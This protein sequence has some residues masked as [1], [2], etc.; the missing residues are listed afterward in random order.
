M[1][2]GCSCHSNIKKYFC[3]S[4]EFVIF[5]QN[6]KNNISK[7]KI[8]EKNITLIKKD[9]ENIDNTNSNRARNSDKTKNESNKNNTFNLSNKNEYNTSNNNENK[10]KKSSFIN[11]EN[12]SFCTFSENFKKNDLK[13]CNAQNNYDL[14][15]HNNKKDSNKSKNDIIVEE[16]SELKKSGTNF[17]CNL[18][19]HNFIFINVSGGQSFIQNECQEFESITPKMCIENDNIEEIVKGNKRIFSHFCNNKPNE[20]QSKSKIKTNDIISKEEKGLIDINLYMSNYS[21]E[22]LNV[23]NS[24]RKD[25]QSFI[26][27]ID[28]VINNNIQRDNDDIYIV[29]KIFEEKIKITEDFLDV[30]EELKTYLNEIINNSDL[31]SLEE[32]KYNKELEITFDGLIES[33]KRESNIES[34]IINDKYRSQ[35]NNNE[36]VKNKMSNN[37]SNFNLNDDI[38][39]YLILEKRK[40]IKD[41]YPESVFKMSIIRDIKINM[42]AQILMELFYLKNDN[43]NK[44]I[45]KEIIFNPKYKTFANSL[46]Y[47]TNRK[48]ISLY[49]FA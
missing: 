38:I 49:C 40:Q 25:P 36:I 6:N 3:N 14:N 30:F 46:F 45:L 9:F 5:S 33:N 18:G 24:I 37:D 12:T 39:A 44:F 2:G 43:N 27:Y 16:N 17:N 8:P 22:M 26:E 10:K 15:L 42:L 31:S 28:E 35:S 7:N 32:F 20:R 4:G 19:E 11:N 1:G 47:D 21:L 41:K 34:S 23:I 13:N 29:S 48:F